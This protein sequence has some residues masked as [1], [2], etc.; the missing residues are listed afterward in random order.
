MDVLANLQLSFGNTT[1]NYTKKQCKWMYSYNLCTAVQIS[2]DI[3][4]F[5]ST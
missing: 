3:L 4:V 2:T 1:Y 5:A